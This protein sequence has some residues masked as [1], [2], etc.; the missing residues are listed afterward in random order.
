MRGMR[1]GE[2][3]IPDDT[4]DSWRC[5]EESLFDG[6]ESMVEGTVKETR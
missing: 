5:R 4:P 1:V 3:K 2:A 6:E